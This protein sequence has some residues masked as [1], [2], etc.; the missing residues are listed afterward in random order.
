[1]APVSHTVPTLIWEPISPA[2]LERY[3][4]IARLENS[5]SADFAPGNLYIWDQTY[6]QQIAFFGERAC[7]RMTEERG[8]RYLFPIGTGALAPII[9]ALAEECRQSGIPLKLIGTTEKHLAELAAEGLLEL[10]DVTESRD[11]EDYLYTARSLAT[12]SGKKLH[13][14]RNHVNAF[15]ASHV[16]Q[17]LPL[18][19]SHFDTCRALLLAWSNAS[20]QASS[21]EQAAILRALDA[22]GPLSLSG[23]LLIADGQP[24]AF[25]IGELLTPD[26]LCVHFEKAHPDWRTAYPVINREYVRMMLERHPAL[27]YVNREDDMGLENLRTAKLSYRPL[28]MVRK[29]T[30]TLSKDL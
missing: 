2:T 19:P 16:W 23:A 4:P 9:A 3:V 28:S 26:T 18:A 1:M 15:S 24:V 10:F 12:L 25:T 6:R 8:F 27:E 11:Y 5:S 29:F 20:E 30:L 13:A 22:F 7:V 21:T 17:A 14:K